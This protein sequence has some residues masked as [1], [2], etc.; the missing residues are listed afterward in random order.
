MNDNHPKLRFTILGCGSSPG[1]PRIGNDWGQCDPKNPKNRR[2]RA[3]LLVE[4]IG[5]DGTTTIVVDTG[6]DFR[7][8]MLDAGVEFAEGVLY[9]HG[10][11]DH[12]HGIDDLRA[13]AINRRQRVNIY[14]DEATS[15]RLHQGFGYCFQTPEGGAYPPILQE[16]RIIAGESFT[17]EGPGGELEI[18]PFLQKHGGINSLGFRFGNVAYSS[19]IS[20]LSEKSIEQLQNLEC[21]VVDALQYREHPSHFSLDQALHWINIIKPER[22]I[23]T[24]MHTPLDYDTVAKLMPNHVEPAYDGLQFETTR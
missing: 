4:Q 22:A 20:D 7:E 16:H 11:A 12:I 21:W 3:S 9:T 15:K 13:F 18:L 5:K 10:H 17:I 19:D 24:H 2:R 1:T 23:L 6:P 14:A 8:Q